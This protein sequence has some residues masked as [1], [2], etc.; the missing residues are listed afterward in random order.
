MC[1]HHLNVF[2]TEGNTR[3]YHLYILGNTLPFQFASSLK[4][5]ETGNSY[6][7]VVVYIDDTSLSQFCE[8][9]ANC[10]NRQSKKIGDIRAL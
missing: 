2:F 10:F 7:S 1:N 4:P 5:F 3:F 8:M 9:S 6:G